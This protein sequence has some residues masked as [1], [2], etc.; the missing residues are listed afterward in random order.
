MDNGLMFF[1]VTSNTLQVMHNSK[2]KPPKKPHT[3]KQ[4]DKQLQI[5]KNTTNL[6]LLQQSIWLKF[7]RKD[8]KYSQ[9]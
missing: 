7:S 3:S 2:K 8:Y 6:S 5:N 9:N 1:P 4:T